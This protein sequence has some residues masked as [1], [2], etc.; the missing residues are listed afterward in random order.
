MYD[1]AKKFSTL[2]NLS[3]YVPGL[4]LK[5]YKCGVSSR[6]DWYNLSLAQGALKIMLLSE[7]QSDPGYLVENI[8]CERKRET[9]IQLFKAKYCL[10]TK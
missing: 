10:K 6:F 2:L 4:P 9:Y 5:Q 3:V 7:S 8:L 1:I